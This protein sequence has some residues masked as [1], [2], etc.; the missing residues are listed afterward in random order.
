MSKLFMTNLQKMNT[1]SKTEIKNLEVNTYF[2]QQML[3]VL[4][5]IENIK[6][7]VKI[8]VKPKIEPKNEVDEEIQ[9]GGLGVLQTLKNEVTVKFAC[10]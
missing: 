10:K 8:D 3:K 9:K 6:I 4:E 2:D 1:T 7:V 5:S